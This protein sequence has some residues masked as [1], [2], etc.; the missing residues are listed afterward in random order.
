MQHPLRIL[1]EMERELQNER[2]ASGKNRWMLPYADLVTLLLGL[3]VV[4]FA[5]VLHN[6][7]AA[8]V[9]LANQPDSINFVSVEEFSD[10]KN[11]VSKTTQQKLAHQKILSHVKAGDIS[12]SETS[13]GTVISIPDSIVFAPG[14]AA[15]T[16]QA[17]KRL[18]QV[19]DLIQE[20]TGQ[21]QVEGHT[22]NTPI[23]TTNYPS[24]W[25]LSTARSTAILKFLVNTYH[26]NPQK[27]SASGY[28][29]FHP[30]AE[31]NSITGRQKNRRVDII[32]ISKGDKS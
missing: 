19:G 11:H 5:V 17:Q 12:I 7:A 15:V 6:N 29:E 3:F 13:K 25:E 27:L 26:I 2:G 31:N 23:H 32:L 28:G 1:A 14:E 4:M 9:G 8:K 10:A 22:D 20:H 18:S 24:N 16:A 30:V 21:I